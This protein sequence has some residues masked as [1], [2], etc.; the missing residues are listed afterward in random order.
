MFQ[1]WLVQRKGDTEGDW[2]HGTTGS[3]DLCNSD[4]QI[5]CMEIVYMV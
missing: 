3:T 5:K 4:P 1:S 2:G